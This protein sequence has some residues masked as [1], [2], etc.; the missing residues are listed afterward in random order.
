MAPTL[1]LL[2]KAYYAHQKLRAILSL[3]SLRFIANGIVSPNSAFTLIPP[4]IRACKEVVTG[5]VVQNMICNLSDVI[6]AGED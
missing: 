6:E 2:N 1:Y 4:I 3:M 5:F